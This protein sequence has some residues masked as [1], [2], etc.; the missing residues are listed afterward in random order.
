MTMLYPVCSCLITQIS[1]KA[2]IQTEKGYR[3]GKN[4]TPTLIQC[5]RWEYSTSKASCAPIRSPIPAGSPRIALLR[6]FIRAG[7]SRLDYWAM[8]L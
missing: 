8:K 3:N 4:S 5:Y 2:A 7:S 1:A 6:L